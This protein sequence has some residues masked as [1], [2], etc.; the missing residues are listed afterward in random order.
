MNFKH[1]SIGLLVSFLGLKA[2]SQEL[3]RPVITGAPF[4]HV[5]P[6]ARAGG[7]G[8]AGVSTMP[9]AFS[10]FHNPAKFLFMDLGAQ[11]VGISYIPQ[12]IG[13]ADD[14]FYAN[15]GY[16]QKLSE[17]D[18]I[19]ASLTYFSY[20]D[21]EIEEEFGNQII[22]QGSFV[23]NEFALEGAYSLMLNENFGMSVTG[24]YTRSDI[25]DNQG[26][27]NVDLKTAQAVSVDVSGY[28]ASVPF[29]QHENRWTMGF[30]L[31]NIGSKLEYSN[32]T[33]F[34][35]PLP[36]SLKI[37]GGYH[38][39]NGEK[40]YLSFYAEALKLLVPA[41]ND[42]REL[43]DSSAIGGVFSSFTDAP[44][45]FSEEMKEV[46]LTLGTELNFNDNFAIRT[47]YIT[48]N[49]MKGYKN[50]ITVGAGLKWNQLMFD[51]AYQSPISDYISFSQDKVLKMSLTFKF[52]KQ[53]K[54]K[55]V[56]PG[57]IIEGTE[58]M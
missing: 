52:D 7:M 46:I 4:L 6:D 5:V 30:N 57:D 21:V 49:K 20:G 19:S 44:N 1:I 45:G 40:D 8:E 14:I 17:R 23:P 41:T 55:D 34:E 39:A 53:V 3:V 13:Y 11:G 29:N 2:S 36:T 24:R 48:Q 18:A 16:Y 37:G 56:I 10:Q 43:P 35:Y 25:T 33:G 38:I 47:G 31:K 22:S 54:A 27:T 42:D 9:D 58:Q 12:F 50:H 32:E 28:Y 15:A 51:F 26:S